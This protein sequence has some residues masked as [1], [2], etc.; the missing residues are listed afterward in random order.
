MQDALNY[1]EELIEEDEFG[2]TNIATTLYIEPPVDEGNV[3]GEDDAEEE[4]AGIPDNVCPAQLKSGCEI[5]LNN[6]QRMHGFEIDQD[7]VGGKTDY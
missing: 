3:S 7:E 1:L 4:T 2:D 6:G 5:V